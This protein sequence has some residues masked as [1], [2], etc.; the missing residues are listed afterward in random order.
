MH[1]MNSYTQHILCVI[2][3][4]S[5]ICRFSPLN[6]IFQ[7][8]V[9]FFKHIM[10]IQA[11]M[12]MW[13][14]LPEMSVF[15]CWK[16]CCSRFCLIAAHSMCLGN[17]YRMCEW[18]TFS[19][20]NRVISSSVPRTSVCISRFLMLSIISLPLPF[21]FLLLSPLYQIYFSNGTTRAGGA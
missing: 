1:F 4:F 14:P 13:Y 6:Y 17:V 5:H 3:Y 9:S 18:I 10:I 7:N 2:A 16:M 11:S 8:L 12:C 15:L 21:L 19:P 20:P